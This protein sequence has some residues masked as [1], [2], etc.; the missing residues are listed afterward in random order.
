M[1]KP[2]GCGLANVVVRRGDD[3]A[4]SATLGVVL[5]VATVIVISVAVILLT[6]D[7]SEK[8]DEPDQPIVL[9]ARP[10]AGGGGSLEVV[11]VREAGDWSRY[12]VSGSANC[13]LPTGAV[14]PGHIIACASQ[15]VMTL[16]DTLE[17][18]LIFT[19][20]FT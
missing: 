3:E 11:Q 2:C 15:G 19:Y 1:L 9:V 4:V 8:Q 14:E 7:Y 12:D 13:T 5:M 10:A 16:V 18:R 20:E 6:N 17:Q